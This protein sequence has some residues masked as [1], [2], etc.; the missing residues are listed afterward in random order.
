MGMC[1]GGEATLRAKRFPVI[2]PAKLKDADWVGVCVL[3]MR[4][5]K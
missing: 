5:R 1:W 3:F 2:F 4:D